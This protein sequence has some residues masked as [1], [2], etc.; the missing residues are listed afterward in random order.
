MNF[1]V[2]WFS[3][4]I[5]SAVIAANALLRKVVNI[6][7]QK[8]A[9]KIKFFNVRIKNVWLAVSMKVATIGVG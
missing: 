3:P 1:V 2:T 4:K 8:P 7:I 9:D 5:D 6:S